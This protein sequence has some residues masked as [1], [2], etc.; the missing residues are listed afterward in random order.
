[1]DT[2]RSFIFESGFP[3]FPG[4]RKFR[5]EYDESLAPLEWLVSVEDPEVRFI[6]V[7]PM[8]F[9]PD[10]APRLTKEHMRSIGVVQ[11]EELRLLVI[12]TLHENYVNSTANM[13]SPL[14]FNTSLYKAVQ[15]LLDDGI[16]SHIEPIFAEED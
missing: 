10:Y 3:G 13:T 7:N 2:N 12:V 15:V 6:V 9:K 1:M 4:L 14:M 5:L 8:I 16:Y 11:K